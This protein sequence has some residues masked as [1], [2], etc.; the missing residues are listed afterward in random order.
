MPLVSWTLVL[1]FNL[2]LVV[3][4]STISGSQLKLLRINIIRNL[5]MM[6][7]MR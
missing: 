5:L 6:L 1:N 3:A 2:E 4:F 7:E